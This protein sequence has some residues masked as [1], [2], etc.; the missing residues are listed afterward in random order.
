MA[1]AFV[2]DFNTLIVTFSTLC[3]TSVHVLSRL[4]LGEH[5]CRP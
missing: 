1:V 5:V 3:L 2:W 4:L